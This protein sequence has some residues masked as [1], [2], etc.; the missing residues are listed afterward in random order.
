MRF[1]RSVPLALLLLACGAKTG[2]LV[3]DLGEDAD[4]GMDPDMPDLPTVDGCMDVPFPLAPRPAEVIFTIDRSTSMALGLDGLPPDDPSRSR[5]QILGEVL[6]DSLRGEPLITAGGKF[7]PEVVD[8]G[9]MLGPED[10]CIVTTEVE[11]APGPGSANRIVRVFR[12]TDPF[13]GTPTVDALQVSADFLRARTDPDVPQFI[14]LATDG[15]P[16][17][18]PPPG[19]L[20]ECDCAGLPMSCLDPTFGRVNCL[21]DERAIR[22]IG[23]IADDGIPIFLVGFDDPTRPD[24]AEVLDDMAVAG[25]RPRPVG[26]SRRFYDVRDRTDLEEALGEITASV[27]RCLLVTDFVPT[28][29]LQVQV[30]VDGVPIPEDPI[31]GWQWRDGAGGEL[32]LMGDACRLATANP[33]V[34]VDGIQ[35]CFAE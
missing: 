14:V 20:G 4:M 15:G 26:S 8:P 11:V 21:D 31:D 24:L 33:D 12:D 35:T 9:G 13:G 7:F 10:V 32:E 25:G 1:L 34:V 2:L 18:N 30:R 3:P 17:C 16:N 23:D 27:G 22:V 28:P 29:G 5:W 19:P 6:E